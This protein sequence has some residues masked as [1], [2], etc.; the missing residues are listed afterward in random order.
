MKNLI[1]YK[2]Y[3]VIVFWCKSAH[4]CIAEHCERGFESQEGNVDEK[5]ITFLCPTCPTNISHEDCAIACRGMSEC[6][7]YEFHNSTINSQC[8][9]MTKA[10][11]DKDPPSG[12]FNCL[13]IGNL[14]A[15][16]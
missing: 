1:A 7:S 10:T 8:R 9:L 12:F 5:H 3:L 2:L 16:D 4:V 13:K 11:V 6:K 14:M 15:Y